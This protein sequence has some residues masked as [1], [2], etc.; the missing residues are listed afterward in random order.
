MPRYWSYPLNAKVRVNKNA[1]DGLLDWVDKEAVIIEKW[2][3]LYD[4]I[5]KR[6]NGDI[7]KVKE[8]EIDL[9]ID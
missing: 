9:I 5:I 7:A 6:P 3:M 8:D 4:Y 2:E 1:R